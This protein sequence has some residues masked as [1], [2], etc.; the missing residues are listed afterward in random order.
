MST[1][2]E[3]EFMTIAD[4]VARVLEILQQ[5]DP[6][7]SQRALARKTGLPATTLNHILKG[8]RNPGRDTIDRLQNALKSID[9]IEDLPI[10]TWNAMAMAMPKWKGK[11][12]TY[13]SFKRAISQ[14]IARKDFKEDYGWIS[15]NLEVSREEA[16]IVVEHMLKIGELQRA[17]DGQLRLPPQKK[18]SRAHRGQRQGHAPFEAFYFSTLVRPL[19]IKNYELIQARMLEFVKEC[20][21]FNAGNMEFQDSDM[22]KLE[23]TFSSAKKTL[24]SE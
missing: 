21:N 2:S 8:T 6:R 12:K 3:N 17:S 14:L 9:G 16:Q 20:N 13:Y 22:Y 19:S 24:V 10:S 7:F 23:I 15:E 1:A 5:R 18:L 4:Y 11:V